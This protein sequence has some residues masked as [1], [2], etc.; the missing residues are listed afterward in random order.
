MFRGG[1]LQIKLK[2]PLIMLLAAAVSLILGIFVIGCGTS[3]QQPAATHFSLPPTDSA[4]FVR[5]TPDLK[6]DLPRLYLGY[7]GNGVFLGPAGDA[8][9]DM[10]QRPSQFPFIAFGD[11]WD[12]QSR[13][14]VLNLS[15]TPGPAPDSAYWQVLDIDT[16]RATTYWQNRADSSKREDCR[17][18]CVVAPGG[19]ICWQVHNAGEPLQLS[20][21]TPLLN[22]TEWKIVGD[23]ATLRVQTSVTKAVI[24]LRVMPAPKWSFKKTADRGEILE[25]SLGR[26]AFIQLTQRAFPL[27]DSNAEPTGAPMTFTSFKDA[28]KSTQ[29]VWSDFWARSKVNLPDPKLMKWYRRSLYYLAAMSANSPIPPGPM[30]PWPGRWGGRVFGHDTTYMHAALLVSNHPDIS[31]QFVNWYLG[32]L[33]RARSIAQ[34]EYRSPGA[35]YGWEQNRRGM[36]CA[37]AN[38]RLEHHVNADIAWQA[39]RQAEWT[40][41]TQLAERIKPLLRDT[42]TFLASQ[43]RWDETLQAFICPKSTD[44]DENAANVAGA[45]ATQTSAAWL[46]QTC[47][48]IGAGT[49]ATEAIRGRVYLPK[50]ATPTG[51]VLTAYKDD[52]EGRKMKHPSP[53]LPV[54]WLEV[55]N[56]DS[57]LAARTF[58]ATLS[59]IRLDHTPTFNRPWLAAV[60]A[61]MHDGER[62][63]AL[64]HDLLSAPNAIMGD[65]CFSETQ[66]SSWCHFLTTCGALAAAVNEMLL[67]CPQAGVIEVFPAVPAKW[68]KQGVSFEKLLARGG[69]TVSGRLSEDEVVITLQGRHPTGP[70]VLDLPTI[71]ARN[72]KVTA[73]VD[74]VKVIPRQGPRQ[75]I[76]VLVP[77]SRKA[78]WQVK[79][80]VKPN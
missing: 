80:T 44:L 42:A 60:A 64:L 48:E 76:Q 17:V 51:P 66:N 47:Y 70:I 69:I 18:E 6:D 23:T 46:A 9:P 11:Y 1:P 74:G 58:D 45:I 72:G 53:L 2:L 56:P 67:Q 63:A 14:A 41:D 31:G 79:I 28:S 52:L 27:G 49:K 75:R 78:E 21:Q 7:A 62:A 12:E 40:G 26:D 68:R 13:V 10:K 77:K 5:T 8:A 30:G 15:L 20:I 33:E 24:S 32:N 38:F 37:P 61:T 4:D 25:A 36:E 29:K 3:K 19:V 34:Q 54:W 43:L 35:R 22:R 71:P 59:R 73:S 39:W 50:R 65:T 57:E 16:G 55:V